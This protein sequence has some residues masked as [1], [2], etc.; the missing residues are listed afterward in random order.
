MSLT[1]LRAASLGWWQLHTFEFPHEVL[2][3][4]AFNSD[5]TM[6]AVGGRAPCIRFYSTAAPG[7]EQVFSMCVI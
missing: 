5:G 1:S 2:K 7:F 3:A 4:L 6:L